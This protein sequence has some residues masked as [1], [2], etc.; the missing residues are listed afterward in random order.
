[1]IV[2]LEDSPSKGKLDI[3]NIK[4]LIPLSQKAKSSYERKFDSRLI[5]GS[6]RFESILDDYFAY[7]NFCDHKNG[8]K[9]LCEM[10][11]C[12]LD[13]ST[14]VPDEDFKEALKRKNNGER[15]HSFQSS[16][17]SH[18]LVYDRYGFFPSEDIGYLYDIGNIYA[19][20]NGLPSIE[21]K[22]FHS[23][24]EK[25]K[26]DYS[27]LNLSEVL[28]KIGSAPE[29]ERLRSG[30]TRDSIR[31]YI[32]GAIYLKYKNEL[33]EVDTVFDTSLKKVIGVKRKSHEFIREFEIA[34]YLTGLF[35]GFQKFNKDFYEY[36]SLGIFSNK[37]ANKSKKPSQ[38]SVEISR[39]KKDNSKGTKLSLE[40][41]NEELLLN[42]V[43]RDVDKD[44]NNERQNA[45][46]RHHEDNDGEMDAKKIV[47]EDIEKRMFSN[48][49]EETL[50]K[51]GEIFHREG[52]KKLIISKIKGELGF[53]I[54]KPIENIVNDDPLKRFEV[55]K[56]GR[57]SALRIAKPSLFDTTRGNHE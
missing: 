14:I 9:A 31:L 57:A 18:L 36:I 38:T 45:E 33:R 6:P 23:F 47:P 19:N 7:V 10:C 5:F 42:K 29:A 21:G 48:K 4:E 41:T 30:L 56:E 2:S 26:D 22:S 12:E 53:K 43:V 3:R 15:S 50:Q 34:I 51:I 32:V 46:I 37:V 44:V 35:F 27:A 1:M 11:N 52:N 13:G 28:K 16:F 8:A 20:M 54:N 40:I 49:H 24:L 55:T 39:R 17:F 25:N